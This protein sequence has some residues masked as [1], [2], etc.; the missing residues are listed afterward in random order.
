MQ[1][2]RRQGAKMLFLP[3]CYSF[4]GTSPQEVD[5][6]FHL[7]RLLFRSAFEFLVHLHKSIHLMAMS[8][9]V[10]W[11]LWKMS[12]LPSVLDLKRTFE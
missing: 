12:A 7:C 1:E 10:S 6:S 2:A 5:A 8:V 11:D 9:P 4:I 3:E